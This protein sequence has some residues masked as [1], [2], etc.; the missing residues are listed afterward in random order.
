VTSATAS[1][2]SGATASSGSTSAS[3]AAAEP[4]AVR[5]VRAGSAW[6]VALGLGLLVAIPFTVRAFGLAD[7]LAAVAGMLRGMGPAGVALHGLAYLPAALLGLPL[8]PLT[9]AA[10]LAYGPVAGAALAVPAVAAGSCLAFGAGRLA[11][12]RDPAAAARGDGRMARLARALGRCG[13]GA[14]LVLRLVP[15]TPFN[16]LN[17]AL[18]ASPC[19]FRDF[20]LAALLGTAPSALA[21]AI[22]GA[23]LGT[24]G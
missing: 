3:A 17:F 6:R 23:L 15:V 12:A 10:G 2:A 22:A 14:L 4:C 7:G 11:V 13:F 5:A 24:A 19:R 16:V 8:A 1:A 9:V 18:G 21:W 20:A